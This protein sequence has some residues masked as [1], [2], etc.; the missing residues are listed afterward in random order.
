M[1]LSAFLPDKSLDFDIHLNKF[2]YDFAKFRRESSQADHTILLLQ[3]HPKL[4]VDLSEFTYW[5]IWANP[6]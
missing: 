2:T 1:F 5:C 3:L 6:E 4:T